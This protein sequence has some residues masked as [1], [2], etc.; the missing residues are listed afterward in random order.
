MNAKEGISRIAKT[1]SAVGWL[2]LLVGVVGGLGFHDVGGFL[3]GVALGCAGLALLQG[4]VWV[5]DGFVDAGGNDSAMLWPLRRHAAR[6]TARP[7]GVVP[8]RVAL[9][10]V[11]VHGWL[12][13]FVFM[14]MVIAPLRMIMETSKNL[15]DVVASVP[16]LSMLQAWHNYE[17][18]T[19]I[20]I[21]IYCVAAIFAAWGLMRYRVPASVRM[22]LAVVWIVPVLSVLVDAYFAHVF[23]DVD[24]SSILDEKAITQVAGR[25]ISALIWTLYFRFSRRVRNTYYAGFQRVTAPVQMGGRR[26]PRL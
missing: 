7:S 24:L 19:W 4:V 17:A 2:V 16:A 1:I 9:D 12:F 21:S 3:I 13:F 11:G 25:L 6:P 20:C 10:L 22:A 14:L 18:A 26:E 23:L 5:I 15:S 8:S